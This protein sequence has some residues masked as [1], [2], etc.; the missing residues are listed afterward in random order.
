MV[1]WLNV[2]FPDCAI[3]SISVLELLAGVALLDRGARKDALENAVARLVRRFGGR[4]YAFDMAGAE[5][6]ANLVGVARAAGRSLHNVSTKLAD[7]QIAGIAR[8]YGLD[9]ATR[10]TR[11]FQGLGLT[12]INPWQAGSPSA[13]PD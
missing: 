6:A 11:D 8:A 13:S 3:A 10:N 12:L 5:A 9:L 2:R 7:L 4:V 1:R